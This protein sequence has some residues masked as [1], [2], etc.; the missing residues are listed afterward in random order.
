MH[1]ILSESS[2]KDGGDPCTGI[3][4]K[5]YR[6]ILKGMKVGRMIKVR[7]WDKLPQ[8]GKIF[9][10]MEEHVVAIIDGVINDTYDPVERQHDLL[11]Y[12]RIG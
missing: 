12:Y 3:Y 9:A 1:R 10:V 5:T 8:Q 4:P 11:G 7:S 2:A 6:R